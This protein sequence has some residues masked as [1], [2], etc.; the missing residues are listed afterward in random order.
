MTKNLQQHTNIRKEEHNMSCFC[1][2]VFL[3]ISHAAGKLFKQTPG[4][5]MAGTASLN[6]SKRFNKI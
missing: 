2:K 3:T 1:Q 6:N 5:E 4:W